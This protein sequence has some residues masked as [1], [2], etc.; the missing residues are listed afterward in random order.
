[1]GRSRNP[2]QRVGGKFSRHRMRAI[3]QIDQH[4]R[5]LSAIRRRGKT[6]M[7]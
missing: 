4:L 2:Q 6:Q 5:P 3:G 1:M 7:N